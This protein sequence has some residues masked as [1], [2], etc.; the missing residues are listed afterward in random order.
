MRRSVRQI[1]LTGACALIF[2]AG[3]QAESRPDF[4]TAL[5]ESN[6]RAF[7]AEVGEISTGQR[8]EMLDEDVVN[9]FQN[10][11]ADKGVFESKM[12]YELPGF[13][14]K[15]TEMRLKKDEYIATVVNGR[16]MMQDYSSTIH[17]EDLKIG[18]GG[19]SATF[20]STVIEKGKMPMLKDPEKPEGDV[21]IIPIEGKS[22][23]EQRLIVSFNN[24]I[25][26]ARAECD[27]VISF[28]PFGNKPLVPQ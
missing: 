24:F 26:M 25:Q 19:K 3:A 4:I 1:I 20:T 22:V 2:S 21:E 8:P 27:T 16:Y 15:D 17:I 23:C 14:P 18:G 6:I 10:H 7:L 12:R 9:Y 13:P 5:N 28:D 11:L